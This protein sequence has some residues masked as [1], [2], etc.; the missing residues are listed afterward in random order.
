MIFFSIKTTKHLDIRRDMKKFSPVGC[1]IDK[2]QKS[3]GTVKI[4][5]TG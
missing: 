1:C 3:G 4:R 5:V 2:L